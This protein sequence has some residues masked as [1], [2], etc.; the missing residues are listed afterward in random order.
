MHADGGGL[1][2]QVKNGGAS[3]VLRY[4]LAGKPR[5]MGLGPLSLYGLKEARAKA[6]DARR[7][8][9][10]GVDPV[11]AKRHARAKLRL[12]A[13]KAI[14]FK[15]AAEQYIKSHR[16][17][18]RNTKHAGQWNATLATYAE[19]IIG[20][21]PVQAIDTSLVFRVLD[22]IWTTKS[23]TATKLRGRI[24]RILDWAKVRGYREGDNPAKWNGV[25][26]QLLPDPGKVH[27]VQ[28]HA[29]LPYDELPAFI[30]KLRKQEGVA[31]R[32]L[33]FAILTAART[34]EVLGTT[35]AEIDLGKKVWTIPA[36]RMKGGKQHRVPLSARVVA[37]L[38]ELKPERLEPGS[39][40]FTGSKPGNPLSNMSML[41]LLRRMGRDDLTA[42][43]FRSSFRV[44]VAE[45]TT[46]LGEVAEMALAHVVSNQ[47]E[48]AYKR[49]DLF[50]R[51]CRMMDE[52]ATFCGTPNLATG[53]TVVILRGTA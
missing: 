4:Q 30:A 19:P 47:V 18:W 13:A 21:L 8:R 37:L 41:M 25:L 9:H 7:L 16:A 42:H 50:Q 44:W 51:R 24:E 1:Y 27:K 31:A 52:W 40:V 14:T 49:T 43:G 53:G 34:G 20:T 45:C 29:A 3:W 15:D 12:E 11:E 5:Y 28:H 39:Y 35:W 32:A 46:Y 26:D 2:L 38:G 22:P 33:E 10:E 48:A 6:L 17:A 36:G 23:E